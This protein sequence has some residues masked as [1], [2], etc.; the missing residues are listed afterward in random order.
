MGP[1]VTCMQLSPFVHL[2][3]TFE[4]FTQRHLGTTLD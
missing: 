1:V 4:I 3:T 2:D